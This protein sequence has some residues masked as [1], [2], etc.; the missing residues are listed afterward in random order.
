MELAATTTDPDTL[1]KYMIIARDLHTN[2]I[3]VIPLGAAY[4][5]WGAS[6]RLGNIPEDVSF[7]ETHGAWGRPLTHEQIFVR[8]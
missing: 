1:R 7:G 4:R 3:P 6:N 2:E 5:V 8:Q